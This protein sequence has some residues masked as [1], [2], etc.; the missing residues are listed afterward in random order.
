MVMH[1]GRSIEQ[2][3]VE[4]ILTQPQQAYTQQLLRAVPQRP[5]ASEAQA[6]VE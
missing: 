6:E 5:Q 3:S 1:Q 2:G 4:S